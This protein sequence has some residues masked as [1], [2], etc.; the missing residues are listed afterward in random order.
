ME[1]HSNAPVEQVYNTYLYLQSV[2]HLYLYT[3]HLCVASYLL[4]PGCVSHLWG[5]ICLCV[6]LLLSY[7]FFAAHLVEKSSRELMI[8]AGGKEKESDG[9]NNKLLK[10]FLLLD[11]FIFFIVLFTETEIV[12]YLHGNS[13]I[14]LQPMVLTNL[15]KMRYAKHCWLF[16]HHFQLI[17]LFY[18]V[19]VT[20]I[21]LAILAFLNR[22]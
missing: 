11:F 17:F 10:E 6:F 22:Y 5:Q 15:A 20:I 1:A 13:E 2:K 21:S 4:T 19:F 12:F 16:G 18:I 9:P 3:F 7:S 8:E 14:A